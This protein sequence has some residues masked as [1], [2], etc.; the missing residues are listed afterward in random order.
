MTMNRLSASTETLTNASLFSLVR[1][2]QTGSLLVSLPFSDHCELLIEHADRFRKL[3]GCVESLRKVERWNYVEVQS[4]NSLSSL[5][6][7]FS[8]AMNYQF[9]SFDLRPILDAWRRRFHKDCI[10]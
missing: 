4:S 8:P 5:D 3:C 10:Q 9:H 2:W 6:S 7:D 1:S